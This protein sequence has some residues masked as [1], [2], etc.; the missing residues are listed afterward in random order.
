MDLPSDRWHLRSALRHVLWIGGAPDAGKTT[1]A[2]EL[3]QRHDLGLYLLDRAEPDHVA[4]TD[5][6]R[7]PDFA[8]F[9]AMSMD[10][11]WVS[12]SPREM[13]EHVIATGSERLA[14]AIDDLLRMPN[15]RPIVA[16]GPW[17]FPDLIA[18]LLAHPRQALWLVPTAAF[19]RASAARRDKPA[20]RYQTSDPERATRNWLERDLHL[21]DHVRRRAAALALP[22][23]EVDC[24]LTVGALAAA[25][26]EHFGPLLA[27]WSFFP[28][29]GGRGVG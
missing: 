21:A 1:I 3:A 15:D 25:A 29:P 26:E 27:G 6:Q 19:K 18:P 16:E 24:T 8:R 12:R 9:L 14:M 11:R 13:A 10:E 2:R 17:F 28:S 23:W 4:R 5:P 7:Q 22:L 20:I